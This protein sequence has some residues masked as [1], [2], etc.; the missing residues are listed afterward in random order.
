MSWF[1]TGMLGNAA[2][3]INARKS[4]LD[5]AIDAQTSGISTRKTKDVKPVNSVKK[6]KPMG[7]M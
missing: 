3:E 5:A 2:K 1:G 6:I 4:K 7:N